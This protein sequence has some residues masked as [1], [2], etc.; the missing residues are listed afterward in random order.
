MFPGTDDLTDE[1]G[2]L[3]GIR[4]RSS[5]YFISIPLYDE[6]TPNDRVNELHK[7]NQEMLKKGS[8]A[9]S[10]PTEH[11]EGCALGGCIGV[12]IV[13]GMAL[14]LILVVLGLLSIIF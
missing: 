8:Q 10:S 2:W 9:S 11:N 6:K 5:S 12:A 14:A 7:W 1:H 3:I 4:K 13:I